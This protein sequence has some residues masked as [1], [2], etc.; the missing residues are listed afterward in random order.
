MGDKEMACRS[1][2]DTPELLR[3]VIQVYVLA[4]LRS[5][6]LV[7]GYVLPMGAALFFC[8]GPVFVV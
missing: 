1:V 5:R 3:I 4:R 6:R 7:I 8:V 2:L